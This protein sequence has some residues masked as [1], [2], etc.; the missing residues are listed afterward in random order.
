MEKLKHEKFQLEYNKDNTNAVNAFFSVGELKQAIM[1]A[2]DTAPGRDGIG[3]QTLRHLDFPVLEEVLKLNTMWEGGIL[4]R[5]W[6]H[7]VIMPI[8]KP[9]RTNG[10]SQRNRSSFKVWILFYY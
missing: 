9:D 6:K 4:R 2:K 3:Y 8:F 1:K 7:A 5:E 10:Y